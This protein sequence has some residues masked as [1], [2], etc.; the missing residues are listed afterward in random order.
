VPLPFVVPAMSIV[1]VPRRTFWDLELE[2]LPARQR[3]LSDSAL[4]LGMQEDRSSRTSSNCADAVSERST[5]PPDD[6]SVSTSERSLWGDSETEEPSTSAVCLPPRTGVA[7]RTPAGQ[8]NTRAKKAFDGTEKLISKPIAVVVDGKRTTIVLRRLPMTWTR[9]DLVCFLASRGF[10][11][12]FDFAY[13]PINFKKGRSFGFALVNFVT[14]TDAQQALTAFDGLAL[15]QQLVQA[16]WSEAIQGRLALVEKYRNSAVMH[17]DVGECHLPLLL[18]HGH[19]VP[20]PKPTQP[21][22]SPAD[23]VQLPTKTERAALDR[24][25]CTT[26][27][28]RKLG[29]GSSVEQLMKLLDR[30]GFAAQYDF[31]YVPRHFTEGSSIGFAVLNFV[32]HRFASMALSKIAAGALLL[33]GTTLTAE[34][35][36][37]MN[38]LS[39][40]IEKYRN[41]KVM[42]KGMP[43]SF[44]PVVLS[45]GVPIL[46]P[47][48]NPHVN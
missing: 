25:T 22:H 40:L 38:G 11:G 19:V 15:G 17:E 37:T 43:E 9:E 2:E 10:Y 39:A 7:G 14:A 32:N 21:V 27:V 20:F 31:V 13:L 18:C 41:H 5:C 24:A 1:C 8:R 45:N 3:T 26:L 46:Y 28:I 29:R 47:L 6:E 16:E 36:D 42:S 23:Q 48:G 4:E 30:A 33:N 44:R 35:S 34:W 12:C